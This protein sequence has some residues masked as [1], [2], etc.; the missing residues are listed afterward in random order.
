M[1]QRCLSVLAFTVLTHVFSTT[2]P[3]TAQDSAAERAAYVRGGCWSCHGYEGQGG[4]PGPAIARPTMTY[5]AFSRFVRTSSRAMPPYTAR[6][7]S[8][9]DLEAIYAYLRSIPEPPAPETLP[10]LQP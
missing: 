5:A 7:L 4:R 1:G 6:V 10:L 9:A 2:S 8:D 3:A